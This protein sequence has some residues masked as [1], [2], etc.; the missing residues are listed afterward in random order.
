M[1]IYIY[2]YMLFCGTI[3]PKKLQVT[4]LANMMSLFQVFPLL[5]RL[6]ITSTAIV[7]LLANI[8]VI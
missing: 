8:N 2:I 1:V 3:R 6:C 5:K 7:S 4:D